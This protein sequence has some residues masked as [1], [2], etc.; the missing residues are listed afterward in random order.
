[1]NPKEFDWDESQQ[2]TVTNPTKENY[3][4]KVHSKDYEVG[5]GETVKMPGFIAWVYVYGLATQMAQADN[6]WIHWNEEG[7][8]QQYYEK[9]TVRADA[10]IET[11]VPEPKVE[12]VVP[13]NTESQNTNQRRVRNT[14]PTTA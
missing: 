10:V 6:N 9:I 5:A 1:M 8:R 4:F 13:E 3:S 2:V 11:V 14:R 7:F 12:P